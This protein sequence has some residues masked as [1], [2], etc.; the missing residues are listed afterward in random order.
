MR[1]LLMLF[2]LSTIFSPVYAQTS[3]EDR[4]LEEE[5]RAS[6]QETA[7]DVGEIDIEALTPAGGELAFFE[8]LMNKR[9]STWEDGIQVI[10][11]LLGLETDIK[12]FSARME[13]LYHQ[14]SL[15][16]KHYGQGY[17]WKEET[18]ITKGQLAFLLCKALKIKGG[19]HMRL[20]GINERYAL[21]EIVFEKII[22]RGSPQDLIS[23]KEL[24]LTFLN[25]VQFLSTRQKPSN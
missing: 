21:K 4:R 17:T 11:E 12:D 16:L 10:F 13:Y 2:L 25:A 22:V 18:L 3:E 8:V 9:A 24:T 15:P 1:L 19:L 23:G 14:R 5:K 20:F 6:L 7:P